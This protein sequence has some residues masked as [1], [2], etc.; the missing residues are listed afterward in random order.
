MATPLSVNTSRYSTRRN[1]VGLV[2]FIPDPKKVLRRRLNKL[3]SRRILSELGSEFVSDIHLLFPENTNTTISDIMGKYFTQLDFSQTV[4]QPYRLPDKASR[5]SRCIHA[6]MPLPPPCT[7]GTFLGV[8]MLMSM[9]WLANMMTCIW[10]CLLY[11]W[12]ERMM[13]SITIYQTTPLLHL[14]LSRLPSLRGLVKRRNQ[15]ISWL[16]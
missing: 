3:S 14:N 10:S 7:S 13:T 12:M 6:L 16:L 5:R 1:S 4:G 11:I 8:S 2:N 9:I 15:G